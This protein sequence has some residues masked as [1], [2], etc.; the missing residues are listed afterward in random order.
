MPFNFKER[1]VNFLA[2]TKIALPPKQ[3]QETAWSDD[4]SV[5]SGKTFSKYNPDK[6]IGRKGH[7]IY[8]E[9]MTDEQVK[10]VTKFKRDAITSRDFTFDFEEEAEDVLSEEEKEFRIKLFFAIVSRI[11]GSFIDCLNGITSA[12]YNGFSMTEKVPQFIEYNGKAWVGIKYLKVKPFDTFLFFT[13]EYGNV[14]R[15]VQQIGSKEIELDIERFIH[16][17]N[18]PEIDE[19]YGQSELREA[20]RSWFSKDIIIKYQNIFLGRY[21]SGFIHTETQDGYTLD[22]ESTAYVNLQKVLSNIQTTTAI[23]PPAGIKINVEQPSTTDAYERA[24][25]QNDRAIAKA[26]LVP[27]LL[28]ITEQG[29]TGSYAQ[30]QTQLEAFFWTLDADAARLTEVLNEQLFSS[31]GEL[32]FGD[33]MYPKFKFKPISESMKIKVAQQWKELVSVGAVQK[34]D[35]D[36]TYLRDLL[37]FPSPGEP[38][39][40]SQPVAPASSPPTNDD[41]QNGEGNPNNEDEDGETVL[42]RKYIKTSAKA[43]SRAEG[44]VDFI[45][46]DNSAAVIEYKRSE[47][48]GDLVATATAS[49]IDSIPDNAD[50]KSVAKL[51]MPSSFIRSFQGVFKGTLTE[52]W[53]VGEQNSKVEL[54]RAERLAKKEF[55]AQINFEALGKD[56]ARYFD[57]QSFILAGDVS[58]KVTE[59]IKKVIMVGIRYSKTTEEIRKDI[60]AKLASAGLISESA[61]FAE[62]GALLDVANPDHLLKTLIRTG[63][64]EAINESRYSYFKDPALGGFVRAFQYSSILDSRTTA[65]CNEMGGSDGTPHVH[66]TDWPGWDKYRPPN[67]YNCRALLIPITEVDEWTETEGEPTNQPLEGFS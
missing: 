24:I 64:F 45:G 42:G 26:L 9:M 16:Y 19:H 8:R 3:L 18:N 50:V 10:A 55:S 30:S 11:S 56:A 59:I 58:G 7:G 65:I 20:Y 27:N 13:D 15:L 39:P 52:G 1:V 32:N 12:M 5:Y 49:M 36:E 4:S 37:N 44:R 54:R 66:S 21:A 60:Y 61:A 35:T 46:I 34:T 23:I 31:L 63:S 25:A 6:L 29:D 67:H 17:V 53:R 57:A 38:L 28:G 43:F 48:L 2:P 51:A 41:D 22:P 33:D 62:L 47:T 14:E 40:S